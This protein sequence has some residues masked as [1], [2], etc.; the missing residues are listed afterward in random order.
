MADDNLRATVRLPLGRQGTIIK[1]HKP[2]D[3]GMPPA[4]DVEADDGEITTMVE[5]AEGELI[6]QEDFDCLI[7]VVR[8]IRDGTI[9]TTTW[10]ADQYCKWLSGE[11]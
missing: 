2:Q 6:P 4:Y 5:I 1:V 9:K 10:T 8:G 11:R 7:A 3:D